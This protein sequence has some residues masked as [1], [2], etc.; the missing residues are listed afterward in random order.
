MTKTQTK[1]EDAWQY[2]RQ[3]V[4]RCL[5]H[6]LK[7]EEEF[8]RVRIYG[9]RQLGPFIY[10]QDCDDLREP[11][12]TFSLEKDDDGIGTFVSFSVPGWR[13]LHDINREE[14]FSSLT[15]YPGREGRDS[16]DYHELSIH[17]IETKE[18]DGLYP[19]LCYSW[20]TGY[21]H[22]WSSERDV[23][24]ERGK[25]KS[26]NISLGSDPFTRVCYY[27][28]L[29][30]GE[31]REEWRS[32]KRGQPKLLAELPDSLEGVKEILGKPIPWEID[33]DKESWRI[34]RESGLEDFAREVEIKLKDGS[35]RK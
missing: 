4:G 31:G 28:F 32:E 27:R 9:G 24:D 2:A 35:G 19:H 16:R 20:A 13:T 25:L 21:R 33:Y 7:K 10:H 29:Y 6:L 34:L 1:P 26:L 15:F 17:G 18:H 12:F 11:D 23:P 14:D 3:L 8:R 30:H 5:P 22:P